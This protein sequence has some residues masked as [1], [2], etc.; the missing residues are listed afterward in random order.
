MFSMNA[1]ASATASVALD[2]AMK[3]AIFEN[4]HTTVKMVVCFRAVGG[5]SVIRSID[6]S[7]HGRYGIYRGFNNPAGLTV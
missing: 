3:C 7:S 6:M 1:L 5:R 4:L 2:M